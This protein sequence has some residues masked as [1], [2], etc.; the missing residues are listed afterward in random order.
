M[1][2]VKIGKLDRV[3]YGQVGDVFCFYDDNKLVYSKEVKIAGY[4]SDW[5]Y[6][7]GEDCSAYFI[8]TEELEST[9]LKNGFHY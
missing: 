9:L 1:K 5:A 4:V 8:G 3:R 2:I 7:E 6:I